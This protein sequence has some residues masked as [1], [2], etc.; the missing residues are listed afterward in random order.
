[1]SVAQTQPKTTVPP[2]GRKRTFAEAKALANKQFAKTL[3]KLA[4]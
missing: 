3:A 1:M 4:K 2:P